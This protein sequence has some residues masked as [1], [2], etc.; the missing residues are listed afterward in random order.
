MDRA[1]LLARA[2][3][4]QAELA[5]RQAQLA[6]V[7]AQLAQPV[8]F[9]PLDPQEQLILSI[10]AGA[11]EPLSQDAITWQS[12]K[13]GGATSRHTVAEAL[14]MLARLGFVSRGKAGRRYGLTPEG[15]AVVGEKS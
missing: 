7:L 12:E 9:T 14:R 13:A 8:L 10:L 11:D 15:Q 5:D 3:E 2:L 1:A 4:L 6:E